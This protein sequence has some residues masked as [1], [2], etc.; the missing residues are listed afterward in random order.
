MVDMYYN[1]QSKKKNQSDNCGTY[2]ERNKDKIGL[3][4]GAAAL[5]RVAR[6]CLFKEVMETLELKFARSPTKVFLESEDLCY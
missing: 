4:M 5:N 1:N 3:E 2:Y 6:E